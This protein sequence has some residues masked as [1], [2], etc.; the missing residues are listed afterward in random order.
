MVP[1]AGQREL[2]GPAAPAH[3]VARLED[4]D[5]MTRGGE[6][7]GRGEAVRTSAHHDGVVP[8]HAGRRNNTSEQMGRYSAPRKARTDATF[9]GET[10]ANK[11]SP[12][13]TSAVAASAIARP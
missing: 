2:G 11:G 7:D 8:R 1:E 6:R 10:W 5:G 12:F 3:R 13:G 4:Q 9:P